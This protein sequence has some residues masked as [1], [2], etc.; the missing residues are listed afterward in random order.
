MAKLRD[1]GRRRQPPTPRAIIY[2][3]LFLRVL[4]PGGPLPLLAGTCT[5]G[6]FPTSCH[7]TLSTVDSP[8]GDFISLFLFS[9]SARVDLL[10]LPATPHW[11][12]R[13][14]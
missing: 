10:T 12:P 11:S 6:L 1:L 8:V 13:F 14:T 3:L 2:K 9:C 5:L 7:T 4:T